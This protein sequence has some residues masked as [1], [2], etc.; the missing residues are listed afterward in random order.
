M[1]LLTRPAQGT[2]ATLPMNSV[3]EGF[4][5]GEEAVQKLVAEYVK[6]RRTLGKLTGRSPRTVLGV[7]RP[8]AEWLDKQQKTITTIT[9]RDVTAWL[10]ET[11]GAHNTQRSRLS[12]IR[13]FLAWCVDN[14]LI[15]KNPAR[16]IE[17]G[18]PPEPEPRFFEPHEVTRLF[19]AL[20]APKR[21]H[22]VV[23]ARN[24]CAVAFAVQMGLRHIEL[25]RCDIEDIDKPT[26]MLSVRGKGYAGRVSRREPITEEAWE[27]LIRYLAEAPA[28]AGPLFRSTQTGRRITEGELSTQISEAMYRA[29]IKE[30]PGDGRSLHALRHSFAQHLI[31]GGA[32]IRAVQEG[33]GHK[34]QATTEIYLRRKNAESLRIVLE[35]RKYVG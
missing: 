28:I 24:A 4:Y 12:Q 19:K 31:D 1:T 16:G 26:K 23:I 8:W 5:R 25:W 30:R 7:L 2:C 15:D 9:K 22:P 27:L 14:D 11:G 13:T 32:D 10:A 18:R 21:Q 17:L 6:E 20:P 3:T 35:G 33:M 34:T 29:G